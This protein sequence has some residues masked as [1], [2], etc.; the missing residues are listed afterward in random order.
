MNTQTQTNLAVNMSASISNLAA[1]FVK[2][3]P[4]LVNPKFD[5]K[6]PHFGNSYASLEAH[7]SANRP[8]LSEAGLAVT[9]FLESPFPGFVGVRTILLHSSG[10]YISSAVAIKPEKDNGQAAASLTTYL[11][12][13][14]YASC[15]GLVGSEDDDAEADRSSRS[16]PAEP[17][18]RPVSKPS[19]P[20]AAK[21]SS[22]AA[23]TSDRDILVEF[24]KHTG[25]TLG[26]IIDE[27]KGWVEW[28]LSK[29]PKLAP[30]G[31]PYRKDVI[32]RAAMKR[33][34]DGD[35][36]AVESSDA[37]VDDVPF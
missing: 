30:D 5:S 12:R 23:S 17:V 27:D 16:E 33:L 34:L 18:S 2:V 35:P 11:R 19:R 1:A 37:P 31:K 24:G 9:Q 13:Y 20:T 3:S 29:E 15:L 22:P 6:N 7:L 25:K 28:V 14:S 21:P 26:Q 10:E 32:L 4:R 36:V 8:A